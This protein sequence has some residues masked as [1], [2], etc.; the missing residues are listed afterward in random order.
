[1]TETLLGPPA[2]VAFD[3]AGGFTVA[4]V[5]FAEKA[6][7][8]VE[9]LKRQQTEKGEY[10]MA[11][12][13]EAPRPTR[14]LLPEIL[15]ET[16][17]AV[18][19]PKSMRWA[20][21]PL[22]FARPIHSLTALL[23]RRKIPFSYNGVN[24][25]KT[26]RGHFFMSVKPVAL[27]H[28]EDY[29]KALSHAWVVPDPEKRKRIIVKEAEQVALKLGGVP[30]LPD[31]LLAEVANLVEYPVAVGGRFEERFLAVP[32]PV[33]IT[34]MAKHQKYFAVV[35]D[36]GGLL[37]CFVAVNNTPARDAALTA[38]GHER[39]LRARL[40]DARFFFEADRRHRLEDRV[41][42]LSGVLFQAALGTMAE[43]TQR[44]QALATAIARLMAPGDPAVEANAARA[45][46]L[47]KADL[48]SEV[49]GEFPEL[50][51]IMGRIYALADGEPEPVAAAVEEHY[52]PTHA[53]G[54]LPETLEGSIV[55]LSD[56]LD[57]LCGCFAVGLAPTG[58][59]D[60]YALRRQAIG[61][62]LILLA[63]GRALSL[64]EMVDHG[65]ALVKE[66][67]TQDLPET[68]KKILGFLSDRMVQML[69]ERGYARDLVAAAAAA[70]TDA[71][72][73]LWE[74][75]RALSRLK[76]R[77]DFQE[78]AAA[79]KRVVNIIRQAR[80]KGEYKKSVAPDPELFEKACEGDLH[81]SLIRVREDA[82][83]LAD[84]GDMEKA[85]MAVA[86]LKP[87]VDRFFDDVM[88]MDPDEKKRVNRLALLG[89]IAA[90]FARFADFSR[91][92][93]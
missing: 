66:K 20:D 24:S 15:H 14:A 87:A 30:L 36:K 22:A 74:R 5:K 52:R 29:E 50:Q 40:S 91:I 69:V 67:A 25:G 44:I 92:S 68:R 11:V 17:R 37:P 62:I 88:V 23:G 43:K 51:G 31:R 80:D 60:P 38:R 19:F 42:K 57:S 58:A 90:L 9:E 4:A 7:V 82:L 64:S 84:L 32:R 35:D 70:G 77:P 10:V 72:P 53:G 47:C 54:Q 26:I 49:V 6:G 61:V 41:D 3:A 56:K 79:F 65:L 48:V 39:V 16:V 18:P 81:A 55:A 45:A 86:S 73:E 78:L 46:R 13:T 83:K 76:D 27:D 2:R 63:H 85:L 75:A 34:A 93:T 8:S 89:E 1:V 59:S 33:L 21:R 71:V 12:R 28:P